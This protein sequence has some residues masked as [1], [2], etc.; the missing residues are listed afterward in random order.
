MEVVALIL[1]LGMA[2]P[3]SLV[4]LALLVDLILLGYVIVLESIGSGRRARAAIAG[5]AHRHPLL[6][7]R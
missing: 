5:F 4:L 6:A 3:I 7:T 1:L 2:V